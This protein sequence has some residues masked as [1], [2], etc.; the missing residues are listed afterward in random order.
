MT[1]TGWPTRLRRVMLFPLVAGSALLM[2]ACN[3]GSY[4]LDIFPEMHYQPSHRPLEPERRTPPDGA[5]PVTG[6]PPTLTYAQA[7][8]LPNPVERS[9]ERLERARRV[10]QVNCATCHGTNG[11]GRGP[12]APYYAQSPA[13]VV[14][15]TDLAAPRVRV[16]T[17]GQLWWINRQGLGNMPSY[18]DLLAD[19][20]TWLLVHLIRDLQAR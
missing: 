13:G 4:P 1:L 5:V 20:E 7:E 18:R 6:A 2:T 11:D 10:Y 12:M 15:P 3:T 19:D 14:P 8:S 17:D 16:R 9:A